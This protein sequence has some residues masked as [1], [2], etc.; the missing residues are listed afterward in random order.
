MRLMKIPAIL[1]ENHE[2]LEALA[3]RLLE[4]E[5]VESEEFEELYR[6]HAANYQPLPAMRSSLNWHL[7][8]SQI[9]SQRQEW[10]L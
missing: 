7:I 2:M 4:V 1:R 5:K 6:R 9:C 3:H 8:Q 10:R